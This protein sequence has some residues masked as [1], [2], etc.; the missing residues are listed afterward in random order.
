MPL[1]FTP[2]KTTML[3]FSQPLSLIGL[4]PPPSE[5]VYEDAI[6]WIIDAAQAGYLS[7][8]EHGELLRR[9]LA[10]YISQEVVDMLR[11]YLALP[12]ASQRGRYYGVY[13]L[14]NRIADLM[15]RRQ[16]EPKFARST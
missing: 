13:A 10:V 11:E 4:L 7:D 3:P 5:E 14:R 8:A 12:S 2:A 15:R 6:D 16:R 1:R 9:A